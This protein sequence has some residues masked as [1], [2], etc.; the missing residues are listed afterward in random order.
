METVIQ[1]KSDTRYTHF[2]ELRSF[3]ARSKVFATSCDMPALMLPQSTVLLTIVFE[4][5]FELLLKLSSTPNAAC[6]DAGEPLSM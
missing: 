6:C 4:M 1:M 2:L 3:S 5:L